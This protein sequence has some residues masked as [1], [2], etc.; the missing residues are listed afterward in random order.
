MTIHLVYVERV[1]INRYSQCLDTRRTDEVETCPFC[2]TINLEYCCI[3]LTRDASRVETLR[4]C[5]RIVFPVSLQSDQEWIASQRMVSL[6]R[7]L[8]VRIEEQIMEIP[9]IS[10]TFIDHLSNLRWLQRRQLLR[11]LA[12][13]RPTTINEDTVR[14]AGS[15]SIE[16]GI[17]PEQCLTRYHILILSWPAYKRRRSNDPNQKAR[18]VAGSMPLFSLPRFQLDHLRSLRKAIHGLLQA[19]THVSLSISCY[20][21]RTHRINI[22]PYSPSIILDLSWEWYQQVPYCVAFHL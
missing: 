2:V 20:K 21:K 11:I 3:T 18:P 16:P 7:S 14:A 13:D 22:A 12:V 19:W 6:V 8:Q 4:K 10:Q 15:I 1:F 9:F 17:D 5:C